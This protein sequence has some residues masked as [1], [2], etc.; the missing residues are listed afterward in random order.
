MIENLYGSFN[1]SS[2]MPKIAPRQ[3]FSFEIYA[4]AHAWGM[5]L[6]KI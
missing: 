6:G 2:M 5:N 4:K 1:A 3:N